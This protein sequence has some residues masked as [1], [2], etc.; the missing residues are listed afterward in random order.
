MG[1]ECVSVVSV[2]C[3]H[4]AG[5]S[6][7]ARRTLKSGGFGEI[8]WA[9]EDD[10]GRTCSPPMGAE[11][12]TRLLALLGEHA[13]GIDVTAE[14]VIGVTS[15]GPAYDVGGTIQIRDTADGRRADQGAWLPAGEVRE[16]LA[17]VH[18]PGCVS[19]VPRDRTGDPG[20]RSEAPSPWT[21][22]GGTLRTMLERHGTER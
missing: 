5:L 7:D 10:K 18:G 1:I 9:V 16:R 8:E 13:K 12:A 19:P 21:L 22:H 6:R 20:R 11:L 3:A 14:Y 17:W 15:A 4:L 2:D